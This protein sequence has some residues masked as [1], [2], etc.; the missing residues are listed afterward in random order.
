MDQRTIIEQRS[1]PEPNTGCWLWLGKRDGGGY[2]IVVRER[3][4]LKAHR[5]A[6]EQFRGPIPPGLAVLHS[7][8]NPPCVN[9]DHLRTGTQRENAADRESRRRGGGHRR[10]GEGN[11]RAVL[12]A[13]LVEEIR[14]RFA[15][16]GIT[17][18]ALGRRHGVTGAQIGHIVRR[19]QW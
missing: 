1:I 9:P 7:C 18:A 16:G 15:A 12:T 6:Y 17:L 2:G 19:E 5:I 10:R 13:A 14:A 4:A 11:G 8:D 3:R